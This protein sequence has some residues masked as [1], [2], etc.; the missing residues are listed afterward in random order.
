M[1]E[2]KNATIES[3]WL[4]DSEHGSL[5][6]YVTL[7]YGGGSGQGFGGYALYTPESRRTPNGDYGGRWV[8]RCMQVAGVDRWERMVG[9]TVRAKIK[10]GLV[11]AIGHITK[12]IWFCPNEE[13]KE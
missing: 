7:D 11:V 8:W 1:E 12:D 13:F 5:S 9:K 6:S 10:G 4:G 2:I 3:V